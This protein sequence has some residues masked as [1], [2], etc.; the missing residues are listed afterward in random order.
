MGFWGLK[1]KGFAIGTGGKTFEALDAPYVQALET[2]LDEVLP[3]LAEGIRSGRFVV[4]NEDANCTGRCV[5]R[6]VCRVNQLRPLADQL[7]KKTPPPIDPTLAIGKAG[8]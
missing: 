1:E 7:G 4:E 6:T 2:I 3:R 8:P 5:Y